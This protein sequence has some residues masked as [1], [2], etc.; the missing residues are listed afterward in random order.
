MISGE[1]RQ[2]RRLGKSAI[3]E[4]VDGVRI[5]R[6]RSTIKERGDQP[7]VM[8][9]PVGPIGLKIPTRLAR[10]SFKITA[11]LTERQSS[12]ANVAVASGQGCG[13]RFGVFPHSTNRLNNSLDR[14]E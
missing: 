11:C 5:L 9:L 8:G 1:C 14:S 3:L 7:P 10:S 2:K 6:E 12:A 4:E 13:P